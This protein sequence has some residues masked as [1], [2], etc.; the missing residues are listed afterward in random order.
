MEDGAIFII[1]IIMLAVWIGVSCIVGNFGRERKIGYAC[2]FWC[3]FLLSPL[4]AMLFVLASD[5]VERKPVKTERK[6]VKSLTPAQIKKLN[7]EQQ[8]RIAHKKKVDRTILIVLGS[9]IIFLIILSVA[10]KS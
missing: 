10:T 9:I 4:L 1:V 7:E 6:P 2:A 8:K 3:S 5:K